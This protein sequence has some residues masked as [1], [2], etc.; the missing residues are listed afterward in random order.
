MVANPAVERTACMLRLL[1]KALM[2][3][4]ILNSKG[5]RFCA[6]ILIFQSLL[7]SCDRAGY[8]WGGP[9]GLRTI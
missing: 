2:L 8:F 6:G 1:V 9:R 5:Q 7:I 3:T 4:L